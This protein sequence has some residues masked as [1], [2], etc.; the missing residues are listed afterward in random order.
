MRLLLEKVVAFFLEEGAFFFDFGEGGG[1]A[2][3][4]FTEAGGGFVP[5]GELGAGVL[6]G[7]VGSLDFRGAGKRLSEG[8]LFGDALPLPGQEVV[9]PYLGCG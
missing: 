9:P 8:L 2:G 5:G 7:L 1:A 6:P 3:F 4:V